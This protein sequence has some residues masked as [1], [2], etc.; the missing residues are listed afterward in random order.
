MLDDSFSRLDVHAFV[1][2]NGVLSRFVYVTPYMVDQFIFREWGATGLGAKR[3][4]VDGVLGLFNNL[5]AIL[6]RLRLFS[7][8]ALVLL[9]G[10]CRP[11]SATSKLSSTLLLVDSEPE[12]SFF[13]AVH[14]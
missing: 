9:V 6:F 14:G 4:S 10:N 8:A 13:L 2:S 1:D 3:D 7:M 12:N 11:Q 5:V